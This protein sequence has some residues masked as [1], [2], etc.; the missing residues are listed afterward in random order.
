MNYITAPP[1]ESEGLIISSK[2]LYEW[3]ATKGH[4]LTFA[5]FDSVQSVT[6]CNM[7]GAR[8]FQVGEASALFSK[9]T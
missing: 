1:P 4:H 8:A 2:N 6:P 5:F 3:Y 7:V 9:R